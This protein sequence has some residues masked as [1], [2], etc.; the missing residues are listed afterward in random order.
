MGLGIY[1]EEKKRASL[2][3]NSQLKEYLEI[4]TK[5]IMEEI[6]HSYEIE[7]IDDV[8]HLRIELE[9]KIVL[10]VNSSRKTAESLARKRYGMRIDA[11]RLTRFTGPIIGAGGGQQAEFHDE[12]RFDKELICSMLEDSTIVGEETNSDTLPDLVAIDPNFDFLLQ[13]SGYPLYSLYRSPAF[14]LYAVTRKPDS[15]EYNLGYPNMIDSYYATLYHGHIDGVGRMFDLPSGFHTIVPL[16]HR[17]DIE[18]AGFWPNGDGSW[19]ESV[20][21]KGSRSNELATLD[22]ESINDSIQA[23][24]Q[25]VSDILFWPSDS[26]NATEETHRPEGTNHKEILLVYEENRFIWEGLIHSLRSE[27]SLP[28]YDDGSMDNPIEDIFE[29]VDLSVPW[30][31][32]VLQEVLEPGNE[33]RSFRNK[34]AH[35]PLSF[36]E[37]NNR[38]ASSFLSE[39]KKF[40]YF[41]DILEIY[42]PKDITMYTYYIPKGID[43]KEAVDDTRWTVVAWQRLMQWAKHLLKANMF[44]I[45]ARV[46]DGAECNLHTKIF[47]YHNVDEKIFHLESDSINKKQIISQ[48]RPPLENLRDFVMD[49]KGENFED[50]IEELRQNQHKGT[51]EII[52]VEHIVRKETH[53]ELIELI[54]EIVAWKKIKEALKLKGSSKQY[55]RT[56]KTEAIGELLAHFGYKSLR[57]NRPSLTN[58]IAK[59]KLFNPDEWSSK[60]M[61]YQ[62]I[63][64]GQEIEWYLRLCLKGT[65]RKERKSSE[66][67]K[68]MAEILSLSY[69]NLEK[70]NLGSLVNEDLPKLFEKFELGQYPKQQIRDALVSSRNRITHPGD[71]E[72]KLSDDEITK[73]GNRFLESGSKFLEL[74]KGTSLTHPIPLTIT[75]IK[76]THHGYV[77]ISGNTLDGNELIF[78]H[79]NSSYEL[80]VGT[81]WYMIAVNNPIR[82]NPIMFDY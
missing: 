20:I 21:F 48:S 30:C 18:R 9:S 15:P 63:S 40:E 57:N 33:L 24:T 53:D 79:P 34:L 10:V 76:E 4:N 82:I 29:N 65:L 81:T 43:A 37:Y 67:S 38:H 6:N 7:N 5:R 8:R 39:Y 12:V 72:P 36:E 60:E 16:L 56:Q 55:E 74:L 61:E 35:S 19:S 25:F 49:N 11:P 44:S 70:R 66:V 64:M 46:K 13:P 50:M 75:S 71:D 68:Y 31:H 52:F 62:V 17:G 32:N 28:V 54:S 14:S 22:E 3:G 78:I 26:I 2:L 51:D 42:D 23:A 69:Y 41:A 77:E 27:F 80:K 59:M 58:L 73:H 45:A 1:M 47:H